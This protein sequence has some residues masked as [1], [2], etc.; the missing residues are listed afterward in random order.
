MKT[1][2]LFLLLV[3][4]LLVNCAKDDVKDTSLQSENIN[5]KVK[6][7]TI[8]HYRAE[9]HSGEV[10]KKDYMY[11]PIIRMSPG[12]E[13]ISENEDYNTTG[14][15]A[16]LYFNKKGYLDSVL[17]FDKNN[18][19]ILKSEYKESGKPLRRM[20]YQGDNVESETE[21]KYQDSRLS[22]C[23]YNDKWGTSVT[24]YKVNPNGL[25]EEE[26]K[27]DEDGNMRWKKENTI[28]NGRIVKTIYYPGEFLHPELLED[29]EDDTDEALPTITEYVY[30]GDVLTTVKR[31][32]GDDINEYFLNENGNV[33]K[34]SGNDTPTYQYHY[35]SNNDLEMFGA[36]N[37]YDFD[38]NRINFHLTYEYDEH[39]NWIKR[40]AYSGNK[41]IQLDEREIEYY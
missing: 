14:S 29:P 12:K 34:S 21:Y 36:G 8:S 37:L 16:T 9:M 27:Y 20:K 15:I 30:V 31:T 25:I 5:G 10:V 41:P 13:Y 22:E 19:L 24:K 39:N 33:V 32:H 2:Q 26:R 11:S 4:A 18:K 23:T 7:I 17:I 3:A 1:K 35:N 6:F 28:E 38:G 40:V